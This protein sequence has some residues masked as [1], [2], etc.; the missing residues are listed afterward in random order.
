MDDFATCFDENMQALFI[1]KFSIL[2]P[3]DTFKEV[4]KNI[5]DETHLLIGVER[6]QIGPQPKYFG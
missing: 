1:L 6:V 4:I 5:V 3:K 2:G